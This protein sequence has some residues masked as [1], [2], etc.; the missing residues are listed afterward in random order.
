MSN[1][2]GIS[3]YKTLLKKIKFS[4]FLIF[5]K[6]EYKVSIFLINNKMKY[7]FDFIAFIS[8][9]NS[10]EKDLENIL[11]K[12]FS[13]EDLFKTKDLLSK[14]AKFILDY[15][16]LKKSKFLF[17][18]VNNGINTINNKEKLNKFFITFLKE[19]YITQTKLDVLCWIIE[20][21]WIINYDDEYYNKIDILEN[22]DNLK[23]IQE[24]LGLIKKD[25]E[26]Y[27]K[28]YKDEFKV[29]EIKTKSKHKNTI[30]ELLD[31]K[32]R[33]ILPDNLFFNE[34]NW[35]LFYNKKFI[36][37]IKPWIRS[38]KLFLVL[39]RNIDKCMPY[40]ELKLLMGIWRIESNLTV[41]FS[42]IVTK[43]LPKKVQKFIKKERNW[44]TLLSYINEKNR[45]SY[46]PKYPLRQK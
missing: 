33:W 3:K 36:C 16:Y 5:S 42:E 28:K 44:Y 9:L 13:D 21:W 17:R 2:S 31:F 26:E 22:T 6:N 23:I 30:S 24:F 4:L 11:N 39:Y 20:S 12:W 25:M 29:K 1:N 19:D 35:D 34:E 37:N 27:V 43:E 14:L 40:S 45:I 10:L 41:Y 15:I 46:Y 32:F 38:F 7:S 18:S 8:R